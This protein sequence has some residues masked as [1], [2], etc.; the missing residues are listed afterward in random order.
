V[1]VT[2]PDGR[3]VILEGVLQALGPDRLRFGARKSDR[4]F[5][6]VVV[7][8]KGLWFWSTEMPERPASPAGVSPSRLIAAWSLV[9]GDFFLRGNPAIE[10]RG[11]GSFVCM[12]REEGGGGLIACEVDRNTL[13][14]R[15]CRFHDAKGQEQGSIVLDRYR[16]V[17]GIAWPTQID[18]EGREGRISVRMADVRINAEPPADAFTPP[19]D[20]AWTP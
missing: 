16:V 3:A 8:P 5:L 18:A 7:N 14:I 12:R 4:E 19:P 9:A 11:G 15:R 17:A 6:G 20:A 2:P 13:T 1:E 10:D